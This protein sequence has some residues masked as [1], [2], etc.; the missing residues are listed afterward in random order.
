[1]ELKFKIEKQ[2]IRCTNAVSIVEDS[3]NFVTASFIFDE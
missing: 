2:S 1:M 3:V